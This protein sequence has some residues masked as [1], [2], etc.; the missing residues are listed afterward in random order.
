MDLQAQLAQQR[1]ANDQAIAQA[2]LAAAQ[3]SRPVAPPSYAPP[4]PRSGRS[5]ADAMSGRAWGRR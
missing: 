3:A 2:N 5:F 1:M 4:P